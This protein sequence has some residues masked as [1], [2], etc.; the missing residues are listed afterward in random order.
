MSGK[1]KEAIELLQN[2]KEA[3][4]L[5]DLL[6]PEL[7]PYVERMVDGITDLKIRSIKRYEEEGFSREH[8][9]FLTASTHIGM[10]KSLKEMSKTK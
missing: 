8:A 1:L 4:E 10:M 2:A 9:I 6:I 7:Y 5:A 3:K